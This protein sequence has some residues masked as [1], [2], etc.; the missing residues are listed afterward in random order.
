[1]GCKRVVGCGMV[2][3][4][5]RESRVSRAYCI[6]TEADIQ[7]RFQQQNT[8]VS[9]RYIQKQTESQ[10]LTHISSYSATKH[11]TQQIFVYTQ[12]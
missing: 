7:L 8:S 11:H 6:Y 4:R 10:H 1:M 5:I 2:G 3:A 12:K 9:G